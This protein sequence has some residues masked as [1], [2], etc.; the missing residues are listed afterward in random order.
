MSSSTTSSDSEYSSDSESYTSSSS[1]YS[2]EEESSK[3]KNIKKGKSSKSVAP[4][5]KPIQGP[6]GDQ[7]PVGPP[8]P[9]GDQGPAGI[10]G[11]PGPAGDGPFVIQ[12]N[13]KSFYN[14]YSFLTNGNTQDIAPG[15]S[16]SFNLNTTPPTDSIFNSSATGIN[17]ST[18]GSYYVFFQ[19]TALG[20]GN[21]VLALND[22]EQPQ[23][24]LAKN[25]GIQQVVCGTII[26]TTEPNTILSV[27]NPLKGI[28]TLRLTANEGGP[29]GIS[30]NLVIISL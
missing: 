22:I 27:K 18:P 17:L 1:S 16:I 2:S 11:P 14:S 29:L 21:L 8:G 28:S 10:Q 7:G 30:N 13:R 19:L 25:E 15:T 26:T 24:L 20:R 5:Q 9:V 12:D 23:T 6:T 4:I 3:K